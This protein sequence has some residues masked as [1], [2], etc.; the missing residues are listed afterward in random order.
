MTATALSPTPRMPNVDAGVIEEARAR[1]RRHRILAAAAA[2]AAVTAV[3]LVALTGPSVGPGARGVGAAPGG[4]T[5][6]AGP[7]TVT[8]PADWQWRILR[9]YWFHRGCTAPA[10]DITLASYR[11]PALVV[12]QGGGAPVVVPPN[13]VQLSIGIASIRSTATPWK[14]WRLSNRALRPYHPVVDP[15]S[16]LDPNRIR[17]EVVLTPSGPA[18]AGAVLGSMPMPSTAL[19]AANGV[20]RSIRVDRRYACR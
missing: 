10:F 16:G 11:R 14:H 2:V 4:Q 19:A 9:G 8:L 5:V 12:Q 13:Q 1:Q 15:V 20:L 6:H 3:G 17:A 18:T 7:L